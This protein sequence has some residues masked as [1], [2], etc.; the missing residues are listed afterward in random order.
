MSFWRNGTINVRC[1]KLIET[2]RWKFDCFMNN[3]NQEIAQQS[4]KLYSLVN[5]VP[6]FHVADNACK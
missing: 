4:S 3:E 2:T 1:W 6:I 5:E